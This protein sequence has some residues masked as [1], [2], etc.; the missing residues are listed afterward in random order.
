LPEGPQRDF[1]A[2]LDKGYVAL[3]ILRYQVRPGENGC[4]EE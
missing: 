3:L 4:V 1:I 2:S